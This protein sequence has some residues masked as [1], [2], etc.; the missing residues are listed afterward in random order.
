MTDPYIKLTDQEVRNVLA[1]KQTQIRR[2]I[3]PQPTHFN[4]AGVPRRAVPAGGPSDVIRCPYGKPGDRLW[5]RE[6]WGF[7]KR[8]EDTR[9]LEPVVTYRADDAAHLFPV[10]RW[11]PSIHMPR[12][13]SRITL[14]ITGVRIERLQDISEAD[15]EAEGIVR[16]VRDP[17]LGCGGRPG[18]RWAENEYAGTAL[19]GYELLWEK[20]NGPGAWS[21]NPYVWVLTF[22]RVQP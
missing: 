8:T 22:D 2:A 6:T 16:E 14:R 19:H 12:H 10:N 5:V 1:G 9:G 21:R 20:I 4:P 17:G 11:R 18:W 7:E 15:A 13:L 3:R